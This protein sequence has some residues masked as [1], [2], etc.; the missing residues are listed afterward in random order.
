MLFESNA[1]P[2]RAT[3]SVFF[4]V[5]ETRF[6]LIKLAFIKKG[7]LYMFW[8]VSGII[9]GIV[10]VTTFA[11]QIVCRILAISISIPVSLINA[12]IVCYLIITNKKYTK[13]VLRFT[14]LCMF[15]AALLGLIQVTFFRQYSVL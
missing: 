9:L 13:K 3:R 5:Q 8:N 7:R 14:M 11:V 1:A 15:L 12:L 10:L 4:P 2:L 6:F